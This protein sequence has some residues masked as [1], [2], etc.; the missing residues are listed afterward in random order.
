V[1]DSDLVH[2]IFYAQ[3][4]NAFGLVSVQNGRKTD[5]AA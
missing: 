1:F 5:T 3:I 2:D 4:M